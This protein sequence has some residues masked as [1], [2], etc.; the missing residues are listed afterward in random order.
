MNANARIVN[1]AY[2]IAIYKYKR[3]KKLKILTIA[4]MKF[5]WEKHT[6]NSQQRHHFRTEL[7]LNAFQTIYSKVNNK[8]RKELNKALVQFWLLLQMQTAYM[9]HETRERSVLPK[10]ICC[11]W[12][13]KN[14]PSKQR[15]KHHFDAVVLTFHIYIF[16]LCFLIHI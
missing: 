2:L 8:I 6:N 9:L 11:N 10:M 16:C 12:Y 3:Q 7:W 13:K 14:T 1:T 4:I 5:N 15:H